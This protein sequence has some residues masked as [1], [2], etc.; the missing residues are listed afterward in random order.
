MTIESATKIL[1]NK[2][3]SKA[4]LRR[5][6]AY[7]LGVELPP[8]PIQVESLHTKC[9]QAFCEL[10]KAKTGLDYMFVAKD[11]GALKQV[12]LKVEGILQVATEENVILTFRALIEKLPDWY[13]QNAFSLPV[14]N[15]KFNEI[16]ANIKNNGA[17]KKQPISESYKDRIR[18]SLRS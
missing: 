6:L 16:A 11:A 15:K 7:V 14:I 2:R 9:K 5:A 12:L 18:R 4:E 10:Y 3:S 1:H 13:V 17:T 8:E